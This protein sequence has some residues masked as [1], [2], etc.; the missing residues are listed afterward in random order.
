[1]SSATGVTTKVNAQ[2]IIRYNGAAGGTVEIV[3]SNKFILPPGVWNT[4]RTGSQDSRGGTRCS[5][6]AV[7]S[8][9]ATSAFCTV[10]HAYTATT[11]APSCSFCRA[12]DATEQGNVYRPVTGG[13]VPAAGVK[14]TLTSE[15]GFF[16]SNQNVEVRR[17][18]V[19]GSFLTNPPSI[20]GGTPN[21]TLSTTN[22][23]FY[24]S[25]VKAG[26]EFLPC[27]PSTTGFP[28]GSFQPPAI[29]A[30]STFS[31]A[32]NERKISRLKF[33]GLQPGDTI[34]M[35]TTSTDLGTSDP[36]TLANLIDAKLLMDVQPIGLVENTDPDPKI[37]AAN[38]YLPSFDANWNPTQ[39]TGKRQVLVLNSYTETGDLRIDACGD[40]LNRDNVTLSLAGSEPVHPE[41]TEQAFL[42]KKSPCIG[43]IFFFDYGIVNSKLPGPD[44][45]TSCQANP[46][47]T[48]VASGVPLSSTFI[49]DKTQPAQKGGKP[50]PTG[51][52]VPP[53][54]CVITN[55]TSEMAEVTCETKVDAGAVSV[56][57]C[58]TSCN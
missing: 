48:L 18:L 52:Y 30:G 3:V 56:V 51:E 57:T 27:E 28:Q 53:E 39:T 34:N 42:D 7:T 5:R 36:G 55:S 16:S 8:P 29:S 31:C 17:E 25:T 22:S 15:V 2:G 45:L 43:R 40:D 24:L 46:T 10:N 58:C 50:Q 11:A 4:Q 9:F 20:S 23:S 37:R 33:E 13:Q 35:P 32:D 21:V 26:P 47:V 41:S 38:P 54:G 12:F 6:S 1:M 19:G 49:T 44:P 14:V